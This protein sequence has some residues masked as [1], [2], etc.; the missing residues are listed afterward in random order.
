MTERFVKIALLDVFLTTP[1]ETPRY[2]M[3]FIYSLVYDDKKESWLMN[4][5]EEVQVKNYPN[6]WKQLEVRKQFK[7]DKKVPISELKPLLASEIDPW[8]LINS[9]VQKL[10]YN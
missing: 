2:K 8:F 5:L 1:N 3:S 10:L 6:N 9:I 7:Y 4:G